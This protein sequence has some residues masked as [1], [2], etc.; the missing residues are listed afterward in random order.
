MKII[1]LI[2]CSLPLLLLGCKKETPSLASQPSAVSEWDK[3]K[4]TDAGSI[5]VNQKLVSLAEFATEC[6]R[7]KQIGGG[8]LVYAGDGS[9]NTLLAIPTPAQFKVV[10]KLRDAGVP[11]KA[12]LKASEVN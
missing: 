7:L 9:Q 12:A 11:M 2:V 8:A 4:I 6:E 10:Y 1:H 3:V 5:F